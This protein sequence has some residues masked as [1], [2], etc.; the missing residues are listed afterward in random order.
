MKLKN[1]GEYQIRG[2]SRIFYSQCFN[3]SVIFQSSYLYRFGTGR[4]NKSHQ[5]DVAKDNERFHDSSYCS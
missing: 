1:M 3:Y 2:I 4:R 5:S